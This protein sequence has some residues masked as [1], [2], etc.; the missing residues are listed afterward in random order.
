MM[1]QLLLHA[2]LL[3]A[4]GTGALSSITL[5]PSLTPAGR[6]SATIGVGL[7]HNHGARRSSRSLARL[8]RLLSLRAQTAE[9]ASSR[10]LQM[11]PSGSTFAALAS[12]VSPS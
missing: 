8:Q 11:S 1:A 6:T 10:A 12:M 5:T 2:V 9:S 4:F 7:G 3:C